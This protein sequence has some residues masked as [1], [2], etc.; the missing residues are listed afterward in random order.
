[1]Q[2]NQQEIKKIYLFGIFLSI[3]LPFLAICTSLALKQVSLNFASQFLIS[4]FA[5]W[6]T[7]ILLFLFAIKIEK[8]PFLLWKEKEYSVLDTLKAVGKTMLFLIIAMFFIGILIKLLNT[9]VKSALL[10]KTVH[11]LQDNFVF[12]LFTCITAG[13]IEEFIFRGYM[14][15]RLEMIF[16]NNKLAILISSFL[17]GIMHYNYGTLIQTLGPMVFGVILALQYQK[18]KSIKIVT[19]SHFLWDLIVLCAKS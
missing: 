18:Y 10:D 8:R 12:L 13:I 5:Q 19:I 11:V 14:F 16:R 17:F 1:M 4:R 2:N 7:F 6:T 15:P 3:A 9:N